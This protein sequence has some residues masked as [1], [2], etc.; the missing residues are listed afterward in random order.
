MSAHNNARYT[1]IH[2]ILQSFLK[3]GFDVSSATKTGADTL[4]TSGRTANVLVNDNKIGTVGEISS[5]IIDN[6]K[7]RV[8]ISGFEIKLDG[9]IFD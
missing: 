3:A 4:F 8:P 9:L 5:K 2:S 7:M 1:E 6:F